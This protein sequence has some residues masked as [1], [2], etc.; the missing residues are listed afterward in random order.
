MVF[1]PDSKLVAAVDDDGAAGVWLTARGRQIAGIPGFGSL[2]AGVEGAT[3][4]SD[5]SPGA[6]FSHDGTRVALANA[7]GNVRVWDVAARKQVG[8]VATG[9][10]NALAFAPQGRMLAA[11][12]WNGEVVVARS[13]TSVPLHTGFRL[14]TCVPDFDPLLTSD[15]KHVLARAAGGAGV[16]AVDGR[17]VATL[18]P[19]TR[20]P[21]ARNVQWAAVSGDGTTVAAAG[22]F[23]GCAASVGESHGT[24]VWR[25]GRRRPLR[26][27]R[28]SG[29]PGLDT[30][31]RLVAV[32]GQ[33]GERAA[34]SPSPGSV[35]C[36]SSAR[37]EPW[38][39]SFAAAASRWWRR[40]PARRWQR[41]ATRGRSARS[42]TTSLKKARSARTGS[43]C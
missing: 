12:A 30:N 40:P 34:A 35:R 41:F 36:F 16:W 27:L 13:P 42:A 14:N 2:R 43:A 21:E 8:T 20:P 23:G 10:A 33:C 28:T 17:R 26:E 39:S 31:G 18:T 24:A 1:S 7:D 22:S 15:G 19:P 3:V 5:F 4:Y 6:A 29:P 37:T 25:L 32:G 11:M 9:W 38:R